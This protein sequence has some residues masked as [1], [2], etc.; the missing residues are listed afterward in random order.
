MAVWLSFWIQ[1]IDVVV[2]MHMLSAYL[3]S[4]QQGVRARELRNMRPIRMQMPCGD[5]ICNADSG[6]FAMCHIE[7]FTG[8]DHSNW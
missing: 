6:I 1:N 4:K 7:S 2:T 8:Q 3:V 5:T